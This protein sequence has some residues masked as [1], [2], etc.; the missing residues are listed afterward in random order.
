MTDSPMPFTGNPR[1]Q[2][3][4]QRFRVEASV[5]NPELGGFSKAHVA[6]SSGADLE[7]EVIRCVANFH[8]LGLWTEVYS[9][10]TSERLAGPFDPDEPL[11]YFIL[12][13]AP[14]FPQSSLDF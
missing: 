2:F 7:R 10:V 5:K 9:E 3:K 8:S 4:L 12:V 1:V 14:C 11:P 13:V 6:E